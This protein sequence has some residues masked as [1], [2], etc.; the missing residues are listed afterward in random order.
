MLGP[1]DLIDCTGTQRAMGQAQGRQGRAAGEA[2]YRVFMASDELELARPRWMPRW[3]FSRVARWRAQRDLAPH[4]ERHYPEQAERMAGI[5]EGSGLAPSLLHLGLA[6]ELLLN[7]VHWL[8]GACSAIAVSGAKSKNGALIG[9]NFDY[10]PGF[11]AGFCVRRSSPLK[12]YRSIDVTVVPLA[13]CH[14]GVNEAG[15]A[16]TYNYG[17]AQEDGPAPLPITL[18]VQRMLERCATVAEA[19]ELARTSPRSG[20]ALLTVADANGATAVIELSP[21]RCA[22][23]PAEEGVSRCANHYLSPEL[24]P[25]DVPHSAVYGPHT[26]AP[27]RGERVHLS[28]EKRM[29]ELG[30]LAAASEPFGPDEVERLLRDH[31]GG[32][33]GSDLTICRHGHYYSTTCSVVLL[34]GERALRVLF[35][36]PCQR[37]FI[38]HR[39]EPREAARPVGV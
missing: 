1:A 31:G 6:A 12:G 23:R 19:T 5:S 37:Q 36:S 13:G 30:R 18:L 3:I 2:V 28:S 29:D 9:K 22:V 25:I 11:R 8:P 35:D 14:S 24:C 27:L 16:V 4:I 34:P 17:Y 7:R 39:L 20:G 10:P 21:L 15:L 33:R 26:V 38:E 32:E